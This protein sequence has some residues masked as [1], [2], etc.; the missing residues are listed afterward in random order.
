MNSVDEALNAPASELISAASRPATTVP[1]T[2]SGNTC[3]T[4][5]GNAAWASAATAIAVGIDERL[6]CREVALLGE[7]EANDAGDDENKHRQQLQI[8][9]RRSS[10]GGRAFHSSPPAPAGRCT[11]PCTNTRDR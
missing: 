5:S 10:R 9:Q 2:P 8:R 3:L 6:E 1:R 7:R 11:D 4:I